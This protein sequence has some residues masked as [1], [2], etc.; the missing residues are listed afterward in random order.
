MLKE[1][2]NLEGPPS[3]NLIQDWFLSFIG[4]GVA[5]VHCVEQEFSGGAIFWC[6][7]I[8]NCPRECNEVWCYSGRSEVD[9]NAVRF[10][11]HDIDRARKI[12]Q[13]I[14][15]SKFQEKI[16]ANLVQKFTY[17]KYLYYLCQKEQ[18]KAI[19]YSTR[20]GQLAKFQDIQKPWELE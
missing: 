12:K 2:P 1:G 5:I 6:W 18:L 11:F 4:E 16:L 3:P 13:N 15:V 17:I 20:H 8:G 7:S 14:I 9:P 10:R 19:L